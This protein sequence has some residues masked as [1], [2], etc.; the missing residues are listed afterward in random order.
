MADGTTPV[1][2]PQQS[3]IRQL[4]VARQDFVDDY[5]ETRDGRD[6]AWDAADKADALG[7]A[8][9]RALLA[10]DARTADDNLLLFAEQLDPVEGASPRKVVLCAGRLAIHRA[11]SAS[12]IGEA[13]A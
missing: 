11:R 9:G 10:Y 1:P 5:C 8:M 2:R 7:T 4:D 12:A 3:F 13:A 6:E